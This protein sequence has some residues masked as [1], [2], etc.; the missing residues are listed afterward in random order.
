MADSHIVPGDK[1]A[2]EI[3]KL[4]REQEIGIVV[5]GSRGLSPPAVCSAR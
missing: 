1:P 3:V 2:R 5:V 4:T